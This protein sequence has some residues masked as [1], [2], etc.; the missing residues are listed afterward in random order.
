[1]TEPR[2]GND[3]R[4]FCLAR[5]A[6]PKRIEINIAEPREHHRVVKLARRRITG[7]RERQRASVFEGERASPAFGDERTH[8]IPSFAGHQVAFRVTVECHDHMIGHGQF[9]AGF[10]LS[11]EDFPL[12]LSATISYPIF[13]PSFRSRI[14]ARSTALIWTNTSGPPASG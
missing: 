9:Q 3:R 6:S 14:P 10:K 7:A 13:C 12:R 1:M 11:A 8:H 2:T 4:S 5:P